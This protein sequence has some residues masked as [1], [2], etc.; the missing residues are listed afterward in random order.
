MLG[1][2]FALVVPIYHGANRLVERCNITWVCRKAQ[3]VKL[4]LLVRCTILET[5]IVFSFCFGTMVTLLLCH[6]S[7]FLEVLPYIF[8]FL[9]IFKF[10]VSRWTLVNSL[11]LASAIALCLHHLNTQS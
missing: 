7:Y 4:Y 10:F 9:L 6:A 1:P 11:P 8:L 3:L 2:I 5:G